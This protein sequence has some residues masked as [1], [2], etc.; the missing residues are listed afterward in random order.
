M[1]KLFLEGLVIEK[2]AIKAKTKT[3]N[4]SNSDSTYLT[5]NRVV[6]EKEKTDKIPVFQEMLR[7]LKT[8]GKTIIANAMHC[9][10]KDLW[11]G[12]RERKSKESVQ[13]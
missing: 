11:K 12:N 6:L 8:K 10:K 7:Y 1:K 13:R 2:I 4:I 5:E 3:L 9:Q